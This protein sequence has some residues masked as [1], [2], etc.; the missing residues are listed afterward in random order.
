VI[1]NRFADEP[2]EGSRVDRSPGRLVLLVTS[3][4]VAPGLLTLDA[5]E[6]VRGADRVLTDDPEHLQLPALRAA[7][8]D[9]TV[10]VG[11]SGDSR[12][13]D[14]RHDE[15]TDR[16][17]DAEAR[18]R[19]LLASAGAGRVVVWLS[20]PDGDPDLAHALAR[21][22]PSSVARGEKA[23][24]LELLPGSYD[25]PG[26]RLLDLVQ[27]M[28]RL[29]SPGGCPWD[30]EQ[31]HRSLVTYLIEEAY[32]LVEAIETGDKDHLREELGDL[33]L[34]IVFH[35]RIAEEDTTS[36]WSIDDVATEITEKLV[37]RHPHVFADAVAPTAEHVKADWEVRK[38][39]EK[40]RTSAVEGVPLSLPALALAAKLVG[41]AARNGIDLPRSARIELPTRIDDNTIGDLLLAVVGL[42]DR[43]GVDPEQALRD[44]SRRFADAV[45]AAEANRDRA[46]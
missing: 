26:A 34:Q 31:T 32:E 19:E 38:T 45:R 6:T 29:R 10:S 36:P 27:V 30:A 14:A 44:A 21:L 42:A 25:L 40:G 33:L 35:S 20:N 43:H 3:P 9:V 18:A 11:A 16:L 39:E 41:R 28:N 5:W 37:R 22:I 24:E 23:P 13:A 17:Q 2:S 8:I 46:V 7:G 15:A 1:A 12:S 4:R